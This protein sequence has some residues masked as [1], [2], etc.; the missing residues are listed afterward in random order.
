MVMM[1]YLGVVL[2]LDAWEAL[3]SRI[4]AA[5]IVFDIPPAI[6]FAGEPGE[7]RTVFFFDPSGNSSEVNGFR[8]LASVFAR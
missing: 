4:E 1:P 8:D 5:G 6:R 2:P 3:A 7:Q